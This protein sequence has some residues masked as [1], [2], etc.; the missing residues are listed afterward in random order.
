MTHTPEKSF[1]FDDNIH[2]VMAPA[3]YEKWDERKHAEMQATI[4]ALKA[5]GRH[6][7]NGLGETTDLQ[8]TCLDILIEDAKEM[9]L[10]HKEE[11]KSK[12]HKKAFS[13]F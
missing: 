7:R 1:C 11:L 6:L 3:L 12:G 10:Q 4:D 5:A 9:G 8:Q 13:Y 2:I